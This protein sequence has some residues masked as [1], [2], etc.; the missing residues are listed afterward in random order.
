MATRL[1]PAA[2]R[3]RIL[4]GGAFALLDVRARRDFAA[5]HILT[6]SNAPFS[7]LEAAAGRLLP[8]RKVV[9][10][11]ADDGDGLA[12]KAAAL[13][14]GLGYGDIALLAGGVP[15]WHR[16]GFEL[17]QGFNVPSKAFAEVVEQV[18]AT[19]SLTAAELKRR[20]DGGGK[21]VL[22]DG[23][24]FA[25]YHAFCL[26]GAVSC[27][28]AE[29]AYRVRDLVAD[30]AAAIV[31]NCA[32]RTRSIVGAQ[33]LRHAGVPNPVFALR[34][35]TMA[36][37]WAG[38]ALERGATRRHGKASPRALA[39]SRRAAARLA[40]RCGVE[41]VATEDLAAWRRQANRRTLHIFD[42]RQSEE[43]A[44]ASLADAVAVEGTQL[45]QTADDHIAVRDARIL[46]ADDTGVRARITA[47]WLKQ[48]GYRHVAVLDEDVRRLGH[49]RPAPPGEDDDEDGLAPFDAAG[50]R[51]A[52]E[53]AYIAWELQLP[54]QLARDGLLTFQP[55]I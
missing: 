6:A 1:A 40:G 42:V 8:C 5:G 53:R 9:V 21:L 55:L 43:Y 37:R 25:E 10:A 54:Q 19:P 29:L 32:G 23:R 33:T 3:R 15:A 49:P 52:A 11:L 45:V 41:T 44:E 36:W 34:N 30:P 35:G 46:L 7:R 28:N 14:A 13:L 39:W 50:D 20:L 18:C 27:P 47:S 22:L 4:A 24:P 48:M 2:L 17:F 51:E 31:I 12:D 16:A 26:P 38:L